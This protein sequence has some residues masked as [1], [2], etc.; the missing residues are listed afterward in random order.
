MRRRGLVPGSLDRAERLGS[1]EEDHIQEVEI[2]E[3]I[4]DFIIRTRIRILHHPACLRH[5]T[6]QSPP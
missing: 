5:Q 4:P 3:I 2:V 6:A 1:G